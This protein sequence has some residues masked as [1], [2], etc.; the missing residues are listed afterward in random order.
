MRLP[1][2][3]KRAALFTAMSAAILV[4]SVSVYLRIE[5][6]RF[7][8]QAERLLSDMRE[9]ELEKASAEKVKVVVSEWGFEQ[10]RDP[11]NPCTE[12]ECIYRFQLVP[13]PAQG[14]IFSDPFISELMALPLEWLGLRPA[15][16]HA[17]AQIR[18]RILTSV[19]FSVWTLG[20]G[21][22]GQGRLE[23]TLMGFAKTEPR[24]TGW[25]SHQQPDVKL[26]QSL[27]HPNY[28]VGAFSKWLNADTGGSPAVI[29]WAEFSP[30]ANTEDVS[31]LMQ[32]DLSCLTRLLSCS[33]RD[34]MPTVWTQSVEDIRRSPKVLT[35]TPELSKRVAQ[36]ADL[37]AVVRPKTVQLSPPLYNGRSPQLRDLEIVNVLKKPEEHPPQLANVDVD[38]PEMMTTSD[39]MSPLRADQE[40]VFLLQVHY[41]PETGWIALYPC[42][43]LSLNED[44]LAMVR[45]AAANRSRLKVQ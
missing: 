37:I 42:G 45:E 7:R 39:T 34:L 25:S 17:R 22:D 3:V 36:L 28:L 32:F 18:G 24:G 5:Q 1:R 31:R 15:V 19:S 38:K 14:H 8:R 35:C 23:C 11:K 21:C 10:W 44:S 26:K 6:Y 27:L 43:A 41:T 2:F 29:V 30:D 13:K 4:A 12:D 16:V 9:L 20:R 40:Y 33:E